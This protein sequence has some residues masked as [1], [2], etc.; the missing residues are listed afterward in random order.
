MQ[1]E[2][3]EDHEVIVASLEEL[4]EAWP[5]VNPPETPVKTPGEVSAL[6]SKIELNS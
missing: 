1:Q 2:S 3:P 5:S 4:K 6:V